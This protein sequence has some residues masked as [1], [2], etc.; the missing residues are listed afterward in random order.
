MAHA[1]QTLTLRR[2]TPQEAAQAFAAC[3]GLDPEGQAT[4]DSAAQAG[5][6]FALKGQAGEVA[7]S[8]NFCGGVA[9]IVA[10]AGGGQAMAAPTLERIER[11]ARANHC[12]SVAFQTMRAGL[13]R[14]ALRCGY[15]QTQQIG[16]GWKLAKQL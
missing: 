12:F 8:V 4:P 7:F 10:A 13:R 9:W 3:A 5:E 2:I 1:P 16:A 11:L 15:Q 6:C 14:V